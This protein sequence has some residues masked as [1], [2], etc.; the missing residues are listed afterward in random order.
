[1]EIIENELF[2]NN[3]E[4]WQDKYCNCN[5]L[6]LAIVLQRTIQEINKKNPN[7]QTYNYFFN[8]C[9]NFL[10][11][12]TSPPII[13]DLSNFKKGLK[14]VKNGKVVDFRVIFLGNNIDKEL[15][16]SK[17]GYSLKLRIILYF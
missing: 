16:K 3:Y 2:K 7:Y 1:M 12:E 8:Q 4:L 13:G 5:D 17:N 14:I 9:T 11:N 15:V 10:I 6:D